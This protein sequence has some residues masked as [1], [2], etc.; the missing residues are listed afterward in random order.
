MTDNEGGKDDD[1]AGGS[2]LNMD[3]AT[4]SAIETGKEEFDRINNDEAFKTALETSKEQLT[5]INNLA[6]NLYGG[7]EEDMKSHDLMMGKNSALD[8]VISK[9]AKQHGAIEA[10]Q[11]S[12]HPSDKLKGQKLSLPPNPAA[13]TNRRLK[14]ID[15]RFEDILKIAVEAASIANGL[16]A[17]AAKFLIKFESAANENS[18]A[19]KLAIWI[20]VIA[21]ILAVA[22]PAAQIIY[23]EFWQKPQNEQAMQ[24]TIADLQSRIA[25]LQDTQQNTSGMIVDALKEGDQSVVMTLR[26]IQKLLEARQELLAPEDKPEEQEVTTPN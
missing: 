25:A 17:Y 2:R 22:A 8:K 10:M 16:Q 11:S 24:A 9:I 18:R 14:N 20:G 19:A 4:K 23:N 26:E 3:E 1:P 15:E 12:L 6:R 13:E 5:E 21:V 7:F